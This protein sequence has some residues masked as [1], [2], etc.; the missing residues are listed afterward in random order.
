[1]AP[2][3]ISLE[4]AGLHTGARVRAVLRASR[5][6]VT[7]G[8]GALSAPVA[9]FTVTS[10]GRA[11]TVEALGGRLRVSMVEHAFAALAGL[12]VYEGL[13]LEVEGPELPLLDGGSTA[14]CEAIER[15]GAPQSRPRLR[16]TATAEFVV[17]ASR[18]ELAPAERV[19]TEVVVEFDVPRWRAE[20]RW[21]GDPDDFRD[22]IAPARTFALAHDLA[23][24]GRHGLA[25]A[26]APTSVVVIMP[27]DVLCAGRPFSPDEPARHKLLD[28]VGDMYLFGGP[29]VG[30]VRA[31][32]PG[33][34]NNALAMRRALDEGVLA[35]G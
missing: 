12:S 21:S 33:H 1:M 23:D 27:D 18:Y 9:A 20:A 2:H 28:L 8:V 34:T 6:P 17:G 26:V 16:V 3:H 32:R 30:R 25:R 10:T 24:L 11:T 5:G 14:W 15:L 29:P 13:A 22:R 4:G 7:L 19:D 31:V 35:Q